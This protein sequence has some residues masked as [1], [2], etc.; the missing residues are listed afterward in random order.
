[1]DITSKKNHKEF[2][3]AQKKTELALCLLVRVP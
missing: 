1:V 3:S 2:I